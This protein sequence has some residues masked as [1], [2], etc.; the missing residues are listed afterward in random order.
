LAPGGDQARVKILAALLARSVRINTDGTFDVEGGGLVDFVAQLPILVG[1]PFALQMG[2]LVRL[3]AG[4]DEVDQVPRVMLAVYFEDERI[5]ESPQFP[6]AFGLAAGEPRAFTNVLFNTQLLV[7]SLGRGF[8]E[9]PV[10]DARALP[11]HF[12]LKMPP[13]LAGG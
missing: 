9:I 5:T 8:V 6:I 1:M 4:A 7:P 3:E 11:L 2:I 10:D 12:T 13:G